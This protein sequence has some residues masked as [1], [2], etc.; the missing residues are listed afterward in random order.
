M[1]NVKILTL[2][3]INATAKPDKII[4]KLT[5]I[6]K[7]EY[8]KIIQQAINC[9]ARRPF[10]ASKLSGSINSQNGSIFTAIL[11]CEKLHV[12]PLI[13]EALDGILAQQLIAC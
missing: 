3:Q 7:A 10:D 1:K 4:R 6:L 2:F 8:L 5:Q 11:C 12:L 9:C 13:F